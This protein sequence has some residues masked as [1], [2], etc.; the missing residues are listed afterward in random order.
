M[1]RGNTGEK[2]HG[3]WVSESA[4]EWVK[5]VFRDKEHWGLGRQGRGKGRSRG[6]FGDV[7]LAEPTRPQGFRWAK[8]GQKE[9]AR[10]CTHAHVPIHTQAHTYTHVQ[11]Y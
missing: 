11:T 2:E 1:K 7:E 10:T 3:F 5:P 6:S 8:D 9:H 4:V